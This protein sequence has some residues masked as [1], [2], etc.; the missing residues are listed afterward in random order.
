MTYT[1]V[2]TNHGPSSARNLDLLLLAGPGL[3]Y[4]SASPAPLI[5]ADGLWDWTLAT[6][7][8]G[9]SATF[10]LK[11]KAMKADNVL[12]A[13][14]VVSATPDTKLGNNAALVWTAVK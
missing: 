1:I 12:A 7:G 4:V 11:V 5:A 2:V 14:V 10:T 8:S 3:S 9:Q 6:L 13:A